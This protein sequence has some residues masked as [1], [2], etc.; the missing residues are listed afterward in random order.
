MVLVE[1]GE[2][3]LKLIR[4]LARDKAFDARD[5]AAPA[6]VAPQVPI[7]PVPQYRPV[8]PPIPPKVINPP[9]LVMYDGISP[10]SNLPGTP[11]DP[12]YYPIP[13]NQLPI[14]I[15]PA[16]DYPPSPSYV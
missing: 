8:N 1:D 12:S 16:K 11:Y 5:F 14:I 9:P 2:A 7:I 6:A 3:S 13:E 4:Y 15:F 10:Y